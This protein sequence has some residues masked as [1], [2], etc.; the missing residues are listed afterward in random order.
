MEQGPPRRPVLLLILDG[1][2]SNPAKRNNAFIEADTPRLDDYFARYPHT[3]LQ[4]S[5]TAVGLPQGQM[6]NS[7]VGHI[8]L[9]C[10][11]VIRQD[12]VLIDDAVADGTF[13]ANSAL[14]GAIDLAKQQ[15]QP[16]HLF[17]L[18]SD[19]GVH[20]HIRHLL[21][22]IKLCQRRGVVP[23]LH[24]ITD[25]RDTAPRSALTY[26]A[27]VERAL[28][29]A[30]GRI[31]SVIGRYLA[32]DRDTNWQRTEQAWRTMVMAE[33]RN[34]ATAAEAIQHAYAAGEDDEFI[35]PTTIGAPT[36]LN[37]A[38]M[39]CFNF[40]KDRPRQMVAALSK[41]EFDHFSRADAPLTTVT[42]L[43]EYDS[44]FDLPYAFTQD[45]PQITLAQVISQNNL[46]QLH[47]AETEKF[48]HV[49]YF[50]NGG[51]SDPLAGEEFK[52]IPSS[53]VAT[54]DLKPEM[55][56][57]E[58]S[59]TIIEALQG[60]R[61]DLI[62]ANYANGDM[63][64]HTAVREAI[65]KAVEVLDHEVGRVLD[66]AV[67]EGYAVVVTADHG[68][69]DEMVDPVTGAPQT[70]HSVYPVPCLIVDEH[71]WQLITCGGLA[72]V[73]PTVLQLLGLP[74]PTQMLGQSLLL[75]PITH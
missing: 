18:V 61:H 15:Q 9:G 48:A 69:C 73:A 57:P 50:F 62:V 13:A 39:I 30:S 54:Y 40:R 43:M 74:K 1:V 41:A 12:L 56:A 53:K 68:N 67:A 63:V 27:D 33:G 11:S 21:A 45:R 72:D 4:A 26:L 2:G 31:I 42:C 3:L 20:S 55:S 8:T 17:G 19:G 47:C 32:M 28:E 64:G 5:G 51:H 37:G 34:A 25:G 16:I 66:V 46:R 14:C 38:P 52:I 75:R 7:E 70:Q 24:M 6:G 22:L 44:W 35:L 71:G 60:S 23:L 29:Q 10:G 59:D 36:L 65:I 58:V 49:T